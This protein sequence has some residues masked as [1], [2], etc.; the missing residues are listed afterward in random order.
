MQLVSFGNAECMQAAV[1][2]VEGHLTELESRFMCVSLD[3]LERSSQ[4]SSG[5]LATLRK[6]WV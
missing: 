3:S 6:I 4:T 1:R 5:F 2:L